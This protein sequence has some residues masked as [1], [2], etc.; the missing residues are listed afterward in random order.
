METNS[1]DKKKKAKKRVEAL[2]GFYIH[3]M[4]YIMINT[5]IFVVKIVRNT[6]NGE[7]F[8]EA[9][10]DFNTFFTPIFWGLGL[11]FHAIKVFDYN[12]IF[13]KDWEE[14]QIQKYMEEDKA[15]AEKYKQL[16]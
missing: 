4:V 9:F 11:A 1:R 8:S 16:R 10:F 6:Y 2:K 12:P 3:L 14:R 5:M 7:S 15:V 13:N